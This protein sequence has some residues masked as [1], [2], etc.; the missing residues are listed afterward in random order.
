MEF[1][2][3]SLVLFTYPLNGSSVWE[4]LH[5]VG[6]PG[7]CTYT[8]QWHMCSCTKEFSDSWVYV[9]I[10]MDRTILIGASQGCECTYVHMNIL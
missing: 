9:C 8:E 2:T 3:E 5:G 6:K 7:P 1:R 10:Q 4:E